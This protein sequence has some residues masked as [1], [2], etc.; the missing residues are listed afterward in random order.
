MIHEI[1]IIGGGISGIYC[2]KY[3]LENNIK[4]VR[5][6]EKESSI[7]GIWNY[8]QNRPGG[9]LKHTYASSSVFYMHPSDF[10]YPDNTPIFPHHSLIYNHYKKYIETFNLNKYISYNSEVISLEKIN[11]LWILILKSQKIYIFKKII[12]A[13]GSSTFPSK[14]PELYRN[15]TGELYHAHYF[16]DKVYDKKNILIVGGG[17]T[18][19]D[20]ATELCRDNNIYMSI[21]NGIWFQDRIFG[22]NFP[23]DMLYNRF[24]HNCFTKYLINKIIGSNVEDIWGKN[25]HGINIWETKISGF[26]NSF[27][28]KCRDVIQWIAQGKI[29]PKKKILNITNRLVKFDDNEEI[30]IDTI[31]LAIGYTLQIPFLKNDYN[32]SYLYI[33]DPSDTSICT[34]GFIRPYVGSIPMLLEFQAELIAL[35]F[36][37]KIKLPSYNKM[38]EDIKK[39]KEKQKNEFKRDYLRIKNI[40]DPFDYCNKLSKMS[41]TNC[42]SF[43]LLF[44]NPSLWLKYIFN[45]YTLFSYRLMHPDI[46]KRNYAIKYINKYHNHEVAIRGRNISIKFL[47]VFYLTPIII[48]GIILCFIFFVVL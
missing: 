32:F 29:V 31:I 22:A 8:D 21:E 44:S 47:C 2:L 7:G 34:C 42:N 41:K 27:Y 37:N 4:D 23:T 11:N 14:I 40:V 46:I 10:P 48:I 19:S 24:I 38:M 25:G 9:V 17:E 39:T 43:Y 5:L 28:N 18:A 1:G 20:I 13:I 36:A 45:P 12:L 6:F 33:F 3:L 30:E 35:Y 15:F 26:L 16:N